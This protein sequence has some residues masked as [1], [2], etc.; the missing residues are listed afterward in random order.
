M[1]YRRREGHVCCEWTIG[2]GEGHVC[3][4]WTIGEGEGHVCCE[5]TIGEGRDMCDVSF[6]TFH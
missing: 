3:C 1:D 2:E 5:W 4:K 6:S